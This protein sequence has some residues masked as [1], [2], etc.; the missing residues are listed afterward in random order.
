MWER[1]SCWLDMVLSSSQTLSKYCTL[2]L[3][4]SDRACKHW[5]EYIIPQRTE[6]MLWNH[7]SQQ[8]HPPKTQRYCFL[9]LNSDIQRCSKQLEPDLNQLL[10]DLSPPSHVILHLTW[11]RL[12]I[13]LGHR[14]PLYP[15]KRCMSSINWETEYQVIWWKSFRSWFTTVFKIIG[16]GIID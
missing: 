6:F 7:F 15:L 2:F 1:P 12:Y 10:I 4:S 11:Y 14:Y 3:I 16:Y 8:E 13:H 5:T 9:H